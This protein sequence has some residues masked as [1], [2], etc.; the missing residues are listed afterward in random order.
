MKP[1]LKKRKN[2]EFYESL[3]AELRLE[4][5]YNCNI[6]LRMTFENLRNISTDKRRH[7]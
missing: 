4:E 3:L 1:W 5:E 7:T 6:L 2:L